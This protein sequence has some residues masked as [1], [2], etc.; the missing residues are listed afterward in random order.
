MRRLIYQF[1]IITV[2]VFCFIFEGR[3]QVFISDTLDINVEE[4]NRLQ[5]LISL[6]KEVFN[7]GDYKNYN[8]YLDSIYRICEKNDLQQL[9][10]RVLI[11][12]AVVL[13]KTGAYENAI[14]KFQQV[15]DVAEESGLN[16][17]EMAVLLMNLCNTYENIGEYDKVNQLAHEVI[18]LQEEQRLPLVLKASALGALGGVSIYQKEYEKALEYHKKTEQVG[19]E[20]ENKGQSLN[21]VGFAKVNIAESYLL[22]KRY[23]KA[24]STAK[25]SLQIAKEIKSVEYQALSLHHMANALKNLKQF[26]ES[27]QKA[28]ASN[29]IAIKQGYKELIMNNYLVI[30]QINEELEEF[31]ASNVNY[32]KYLKAKDNFLTTLTKAKRLD[33]EKELA[34]K[35]KV[36]IE[37]KKSIDQLLL[38]S[39]PIILILSV[40]LIVYIKKKKQLQKENQQMLQNRKILENENL[41]LKIKLEALAMSSSVDEESESKRKYQNSSLSDEEKATYTTRILEYMDKE[42]PYLNPDLKQSDMAEHLS[43]SVHLLSQILNDCF[44]RNFNGFINLYR[45]HEAKKRLQNPEFIDNKIIAIGYEVGFSS[46]TSFHRV[47]KNTVGKTPADYRDL[48]LNA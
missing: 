31:E 26:D 10:N 46:K 48:V 44:K 23:E 17:L 41:S 43:I 45:V 1:I 25:E 22:L 21:V 15:L 47:F 39:I 42:K 29:K 13:D 27:L 28:V 2:V 35:E 6:G 37:Q 18:E 30:A 3:S 9:K 38:Y 34:E 8:K 33:V 32:K 5:K 14:A 24:L 20:I 4:K 12:Q 36:I 11:Q 7:K 19:T 40:I 16:E